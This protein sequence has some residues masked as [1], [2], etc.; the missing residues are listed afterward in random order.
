MAGCR[1]LLKSSVRLQRALN[2]CQKVGGGGEGGGGPLFEVLR[3]S[4]WLTAG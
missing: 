3:C 1:R 4:L 2:A